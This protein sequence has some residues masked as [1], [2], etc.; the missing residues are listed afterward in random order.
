MTRK[1]SG[2]LEEGI[3][4]EEEVRKAIFKKVCIQ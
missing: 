1:G 2:Q 4:D 3:K